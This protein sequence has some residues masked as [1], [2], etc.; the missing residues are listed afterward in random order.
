MKIVVCLKP[1]PDT[2]VTPRIDAQTK[3]LIRE[4]AQTVINPFDEFALE[5]ALRLRDADAA[6]TVTILALAPAGAKET[7]RKALAI[8]ADNAVHV[9]DDA[10]AGADGSATAQILAAALSM[11]GFDLVLCGTQ[12]ADGGGGYLPSMLA[13]YLDVP[14]M[15]TLRQIG[16]ANGRI[17]GER[18]VDGTVTRLSCDTPLLAGI[19]KESAAPRYA[20]LKGIMAAKKK[21]I[22]MITAA[23][24][25]MQTI[26]PT[27][28]VLEVAAP[29]AK[30][31]GRVVRADDAVVAA[32]EIIAYLQERHLA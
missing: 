31:R 24:L 6:H 10:F 5:A 13:E 28:E 7:L 14:I 32:Q 11:I 19:S 18:N 9:C 3:R 30:Q 1:V 4:A 29:V 27:T 23:E 2:S 20:S 21:E 26:V 17:E 22:C 8:G 25:G 16:S 12:S 15:P